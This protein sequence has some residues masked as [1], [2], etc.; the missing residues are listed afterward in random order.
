M[1]QRNKEIGTV[2]PPGGFPIVVHVARWEPSECDP[3]R[4]EP[5]VMWLTAGRYEYLPPAEARQFAAALNKAAGEAEKMRD[6]ERA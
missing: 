5:E 2:T 4:R 3:H 6:G 1:K